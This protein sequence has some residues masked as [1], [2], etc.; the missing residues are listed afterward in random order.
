MLIHIQ[1][2]THTQK[3]EQFT[4]A[5]QRKIKLNSEVWTVSV[6]TWWDGVTWLHLFF[7]LFVSSWNINTDIML[8]KSFKVWSFLHATWEL[9][10]TPSFRSNTIKV[11][12]KLMKLMAKARLM[13]LEH[14]FWLKPMLSLDGYCAVLLSQCMPISSKLNLWARAQKLWN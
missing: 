1:L 2:R 12:G 5:N 3:Q 8:H 14:G 10:S 11:I 6:S 13:R 7:K 9:F 4:T